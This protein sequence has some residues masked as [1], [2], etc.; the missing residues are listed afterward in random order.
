MDQLCPGD[1]LGLDGTS[2]LPLTGIDAVLSGN[3]PRGSGLSSSAALEV[4]TA[5]A[6]LAAAD[7]RHALDG[8][9]IATAA[10]RAE[11]EFVGVNC[12]IMDQ[13]ISVLG[14]RR[15]RAA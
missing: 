14:R 15:P 8:V 11:N 13:F 10:Q 3:V 6:L 9:Q 7:Q 5:M 12:G 4:A 1:G 2:G